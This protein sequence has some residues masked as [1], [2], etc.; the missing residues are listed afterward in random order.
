MIS[1]IFQGFS[2]LAGIYFQCCMMCP[3]EDYSTVVKMLAI[4]DN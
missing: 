4:D 3:E 2:Q 1:L